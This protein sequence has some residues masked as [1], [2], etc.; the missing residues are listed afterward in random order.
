MASMA[1]ETVTSL[2]LDIACFESS[3][4]DD[5]DI[6]FLRAS[7]AAMADAAAAARDAFLRFI[8]G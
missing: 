6:S 3:F 5:V 4:G 7:V 1:S 8:V 2:V